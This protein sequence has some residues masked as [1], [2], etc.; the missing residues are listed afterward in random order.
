MSDFRSEWDRD[1]LEIAT[2]ENEELRQRLREAAAELRDLRAECDS[3]RQAAA[4][5]NVLRMEAEAERDR[6]REA[7]R[8]I[9]RRGDKCWCDQGY[10]GS[11]G[12][13]QRMAEMAADARCLTPNEYGAC[14]LCDECKLDLDKQSSDP[15]TEGGES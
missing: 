4:G 11:C 1:Q 7:L 14:A 12:C 6:L 5:E 9:Q 2:D 13:G 3:A 15:A 8:D 10:P